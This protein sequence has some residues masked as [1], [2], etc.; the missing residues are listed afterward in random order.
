MVTLGWG[1]GFLVSGMAPETMLC[2]PG[3]PTASKPNRY[4][5]HHLLNTGSPLS[6][7]CISPAASTFPSPNKLLPYTSVGTNS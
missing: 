4:G 6:N 7:P 1:Y 3:E 5:L 2:L